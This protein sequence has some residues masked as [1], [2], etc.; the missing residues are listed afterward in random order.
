MDTKVSEQFIMYSLL[1][2]LSLF[3]ILSIIIAGC[4]ST[5]VYSMYN[6]KYL[7]LFIKMLVG[8]QVVK[9]GESCLNNER[10]AHW[11]LSIKHS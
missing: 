6:C 7:A 1:A 11:T 8:W 10:V 5:L 2:Y 4:G 3:V 9:G